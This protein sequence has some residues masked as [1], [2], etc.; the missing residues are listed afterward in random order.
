LALIFRAV[1]RSV[2]A[3]GRTADTSRLAALPLFASSA[4]FRMARPSAFRSAGSA[5]S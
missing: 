1:D 3:A 2:A 5:L 4:N